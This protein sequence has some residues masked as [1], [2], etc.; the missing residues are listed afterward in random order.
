MSS[1]GIHISSQLGVTR[2]RLLLYFNIH[3]TTSGFVIVMLP[4]ASDMIPA[5]GGCIELRILSQ[6]G[7]MPK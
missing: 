2:H 3:S 7:H 6:A 4:F 5:V 1:R